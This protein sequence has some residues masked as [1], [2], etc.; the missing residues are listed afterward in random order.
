MATLRDSLA[1]DIG[2]ALKSV[3][4]LAKTIRDASKMEL[5]V[6]AKSINTA[7][8][9]I[10]GLKKQLDAAATVPVKFDISKL[11]V[12]R[13]DPV[14]IAVQWDMQSLS[15][16]ISELRVD[17]VDVPVKPDYPT[18]L[19]PLIVPGEVDFPPLDYPRVDILKVPVQYDQA[20]FEPIRPD[21]VI[22]PVR[23]DVPP[24]DLPAAEPVNVPVVFDTSGLEGQI[25]SLGSTL[26][27]ALSGAGGGGG[28][29][30]GGLLGG[31]LGGLVAAH[32]LGAAVAAA[33][34]AGAAIVGGFR[35]VE[36][37]VSQSLTLLAE[38][39]DVTFNELFDKS[40]DFSNKFGKPLEDVTSSIYEAISAGVPVDN[41]FS[42]MEVAAKAA[43]GGATTTETAVNGLTGIMNS[44]G[45]SITDPA[46]RMAY[47]NKVA[48]V[49]FQTVNYGKITFDQ[50][51]SQ[52]SDF[53]PIAS[54]VGLSIEE[55]GA[56]MAAMTLDNTPAAEAAT[57]L[58]QVMAA[59]DDT[60]SKAGKTFKELSGQTFRQ[61]VASGGDLGDALMIMKR[62][63]DATGIGV[64]EMFGEIRA[65]QAA[66]KLTVQD[67]AVFDDLVRK[68]GESAGTTERA[69]GIMT[70]TIGFKWGQLLTELKN[71]AQRLADLVKEPVKAILDVALFAVRGI[72]ELNDGMLSAW[73]D[74]ADALAPVIRRVID[75]IQPLL[76]MV[77]RFKAEVVD[78]VADGI[79]RLRDAFSGFG[80][81][82]EGAIDG[83]ANADFSRALRGLQPLADAFVQ[84]WQRG[85]R[86]FV[87]GVTDLGSAIGEVLGP[88][89]VDLIG[90]VRDDLVPTL[91]EARPLLDKI[92]G[93]WVAIAKALVSVGALGVKAVAGLLLVLGKIASGLAEVIR[94]VAKLEIVRT[95]FAGIARVLST[96]FLGVLRTVIDLLGRFY[97]FVTNIAQAV[98]A[99]ASGDFL[100][101]LSN[102]RDALGDVV[103]F[104][105]DLVTGI[106][107]TLL[108]GVKTLGPELLNIL[109]SALGYALDGLGHA[110]DFA[111]KILG[112]IVDGIKAAPGA[113][114]AIAAAVGGWIADG[115]AEV[116]GGALDLSSKLGKL[117]VDGL[118]AVVSGD[119]T[120]AVARWIGSIISDA[121]GRIEGI[122][123]GAIGTTIKDGV[124]GAVSS[125]ATFA[126]DLG[127]AIG[128]KAHDAGVA[129]ANID[130]SAVGTAIK[131]GVVTAVANVLDFAEAIGRTIGDKAVA[132]GEAVAAVDWAAVASGIVDGV[133]AALGAVQDFS[134]KFAGW[135]ASQAVAIGEWVKTIDFGDVAAA[136]TTAL[137]WAMENADKIALAVGITA[138][139]LGAL[140][141]VPVA[142]VGGIIALVGYIAFQFTTGL[143][144]G[145]GADKLIGAIMGGV[146]GAWNWIRGKFNEVVADITS[147]VTTGFEAVKLAIA[148]PMET[149]R[150]AVDTA[151]SAMRGV[152]STA[153]DF[154]RTRIESSFNTV[155]SVIS[156]A[157]DIAKGA[158]DGLK[159][160]ISNAATAVGNFVDAIRSGIGGIGG[161]FRSAF[162]GVE[163]IID[164][165]AGALGRVASAIR[166]MPSMPDL[167]PG[168]SVPG[169]GEWGGVFNRP[170]N[171]IIGEAGRE[172]LLPLTK[173]WEYQKQ[174]LSAAGVL[175]R[176]YAEASRSRQQTTIPAGYSQTVHEG[177]T[178]VNV[179]MHAPP[180]R[181]PA[182]Q[183]GDAIGRRILHSI[184][185]NPKRRRRP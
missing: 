128:K 121:I 24:L 35:D 31:A 34:A 72:R 88:V 135:L 173:S 66:M 172:L 70:D 40:V 20:P 37:N 102:L 153:T 65:G 157:M 130:W 147:I 182:S 38:G 178:I 104:I 111:G 59:L 45:R 29:A 60:S 74:T 100:G 83:L 18:N 167:T 160:A 8:K 124:V 185:A 149:A 44:F 133:I 21:P 171:L 156:T 7:E 82:A 53:G 9:Q 6:N 48:D 16:A 68:M 55:M 71:G 85:I 150:I 168:F 181:L 73:R 17:P 109:D 28:A 136:I 1:L 14:T 129:L 158:I 51:S 107:T 90:W 80:S 89:I 64:Q 15:G 120:A 118:N 69:Y 132:I 25:A 144:E 179:T 93:A 26:S 84:L 148:N 27:G 10:A 161:L 39:S 119:V 105:G 122:D 78:R 52:V 164:G 125:A 76:D 99:L 142:I 103:G 63:A 141:L 145:L 140:V 58:R 41:V 79:A 131:D 62:S 5:T 97:D 134:I 108:D 165:V 23:Y 42:F 49:M 2:P 61:F 95:V 166:N 46:E 139:I 184:Q 56:A 36:R 170:T 159:T 174:L 54:S 81:D 32:P 3:S 98:Q 138:L 154:I 126:N 67:G 75:Y 33:A 183:V 43:V 114:G 117:L 86:P 57:Q 4:T 11:S 162:S 113:V 12:P 127:Q 106:G 96:V 30:T 22:A 91:A 112:V 47:L 177:D 169:F 92:A 123:W 151:W 176:V 152:V 175:D 163:S 146:E 13:P 94:F 115:L 155:Q 19:A 110:V 87:E 50:L 143:A 137:A 116:G 180:S 77:A 101:F